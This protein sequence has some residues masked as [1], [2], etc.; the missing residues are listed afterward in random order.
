MIKIAEHFF[1]PNKYFIKTTYASSITLFVGSLIHETAS[2]YYFEDPFRYFTRLDYTINDKKIYCARIHKGKIL[3]KI[4]SNFEFIF[5]N[6]NHIDTSL[7]AIAMGRFYCLLLTKRTSKNKN[8]GELM[9]IVNKSFREVY[10]KNQ[11]D[12]NY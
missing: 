5:S 1:N 10:D 4:K 3:A 11:V 9:N 12:F 7:Q 8:F 2:Y 6:I